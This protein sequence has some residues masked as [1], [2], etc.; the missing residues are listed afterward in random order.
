MNAV[1]GK[2]TQHPEAKEVRKSFLAGVR[3]FLSN[4]LGRNFY[5]AN[6]DLED[7]NPREAVREERKRLTNLHLQRLNQCSGNA[8]YGDEVDEQAA[9]S[10]THRKMDVFKRTYQN[11]DPARRSGSNYEAY[12]PNTAGRPH[13]D[14]YQRLD[15]VRR[16]YSD[17]KSPVESY[18][19]V[20]S[21]LNRWTINDLPLVDAQSSNNAHAEYYKA[22]NIETMNPYGLKQF[23]DSDGEAKSS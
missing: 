9:A 14:T 5:R 17:M 13:S 4:L 20:P 18:K 2:R 23:I 19:G 15:T 3:E 12:K 6:S 11:M 21:K 10:L 7:S 8:Q 1:V 16:T 22:M